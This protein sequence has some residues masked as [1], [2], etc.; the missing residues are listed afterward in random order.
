MPLSI[1]EVNQFA[2]EEFIETVGWVFEHSPWVAE[3]AWQHRPF[4]SGTDLSEHMNTEVT[5]ASTEEQLALLRAH[6]DLGT[7]AKIS[8]SSV[9]ALVSTSMNPLPRKKKGRYD[10]CQR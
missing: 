5:A 6:P 8:P 4:A 7:R 3:R 1:E 10:A 2:Q 9:I